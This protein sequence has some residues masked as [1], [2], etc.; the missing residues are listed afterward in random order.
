MPAAR[1]EYDALAVW[2][3]V[4][5]YGDKRGVLEGAFDELEKRMQK[6]LLR[7]GVVPSIDREKG[8]V[9]GD[10]LS[11]SRLKK[12]YQTAQR[13]VEANPAL[14]AEMRAQARQLADALAQAPGSYLFPVRVRMPDAAAVG[15]WIIAQFC[16]HQERLIIHAAHEISI[17]LSEADD[18]NGPFIPTK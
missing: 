11:A 13:L 2:L 7:R 12:L 8:V 18:P 4:R 14:K 16:P 3:C 9:V 6:H 15:T 5:S 17:D 1:P 10:K